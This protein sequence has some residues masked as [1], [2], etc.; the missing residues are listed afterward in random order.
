MV[1][2]HAKTAKNVVVIGSSFL[3]S[4]AAAALKNQYKAEKE[5]YLVSSQEFPIQ[6][7]LGTEVGKMLAN[8]HLKNGVKLT[9]KQH[10]KA[11][12]GDENGNVKRVVFA[13]GTAVE[14]DLVIMGTG[15]KPNTDFLQNTQI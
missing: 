2:E 13:D 9:P 10:V 8:E 5:V 15:C 14:A 3:G 12:E 11:V 1:K 7:V 4:E 6:K